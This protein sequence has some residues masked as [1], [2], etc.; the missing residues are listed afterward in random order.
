MKGDTHIAVGTIAA[1]TQ[2]TRGAIPHLTT[3]YIASYTYMSLAR[4]SVII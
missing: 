3:I 2:S 1:E 4:C